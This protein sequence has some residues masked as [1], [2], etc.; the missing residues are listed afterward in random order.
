M[1]IGGIPML[2]IGSRRTKEWRAGPAEK[3]AETPEVSLLPQFGRHGGGL[4]LTG[5]F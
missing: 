2:I 4:V 5:R 3:P 1:A